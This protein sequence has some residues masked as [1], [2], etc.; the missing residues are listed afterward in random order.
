[1]FRYLLGGLLAGLVL[2]YA[3]FGMQTARPGTLLPQA[4]FFGPWVGL[5][6]LLEKTLRPIGFWVYLSPP[7]LYL[8]YGGILGFTEKRGRLAIATLL[9]FV[10][11]YSGMLFSAQ[12]V[13]MWRGEPTRFLLVMKNQPWLMTLGF[14]VFIGVNVLAIIKGWIAKE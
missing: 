12:L 1:V 8:I 5:Y 9:L 14:A 6:S 11:H 2:E 13:N 4:L 3:A 7:L 10:F